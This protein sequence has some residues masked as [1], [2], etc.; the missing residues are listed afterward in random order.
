[1]ARI[2]TPDELGYVQPTATRP[3]ATYDATP[4][5]RGISSV[6]NALSDVADLWRQQDLGVIEGEYSVPVGRNGV[7]LL[8]VWPEK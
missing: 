6:G 8:R 2:P 1:M 7:M 4:I 3:I 5:A